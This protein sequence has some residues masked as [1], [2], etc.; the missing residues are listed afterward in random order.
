MIGG[1]LERCVWLIRMSLPKQMYQPKLLGEGF[2]QR[3]MDMAAALSNYDHEVT[4]T[5]PVTCQSKAGRH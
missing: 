5:C 3:H 2:E 1:L 4:M